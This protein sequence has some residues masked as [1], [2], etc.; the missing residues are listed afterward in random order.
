M[1]TELYKELYKKNLLIDPENLGSYLKN[2]RNDKS[3]K[4]NKN[5]WQDKR[6]MITGI[7]GFAGSHLAKKLLELNSKVYGLIRRHSV[8]EYPNISKIANRIELFEGNLSD[9]NS[10]LTMIK[11]F[12]PEVVFHLGAQAIVGYANRSPISTL[13]VVIE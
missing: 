1:E 6:V 10:L 8:P 11:K 13:N 3:N 7:S 4:P 2:F 12:E 9:S 5:F